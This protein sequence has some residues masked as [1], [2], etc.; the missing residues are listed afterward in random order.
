M[1]DRCFVTAAFC[2]CSAV[3]A[4][5]LRQ[6]CREQSMLLAIAACTAVIGSFAAFVAPMMSELQEIF[7]AA[8]ISESY[9]ALIFKGLAICIITRITSELCR[10]SGESAIGAA[11]ELWGR[12]A[13]T[14]LSLPL[15]KAILEQISSL[16]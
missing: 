15:V 13:V 16:M 6:H 9:L 5:L 12:G 8:G 4:V 11:A 3:L 10:D 1:T 2:L 7:S 14:L